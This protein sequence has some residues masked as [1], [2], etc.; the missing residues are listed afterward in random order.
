LT[1]SREGDVFSGTFSSE[2]GNANLGRVELHDNSFQASTFLNTDGHELPAEISARFDGDH[3]E[4]SLTLQE[5]P[6][7]PF[8]GSKD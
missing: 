5:S 3:A 4:G 1:I 8:T 6:A 7:L 2:M